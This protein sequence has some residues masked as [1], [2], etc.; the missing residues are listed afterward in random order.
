M[1]IRSIPIRKE[2]E[3]KI[4]RGQFKGREGKVTAVYRKKFVIHVERVTRDKANG[5][6]V[7]MGIDA[8]NVII[9]KLKVSIVSPF[10]AHS[11]SCDSS[12][13]FFGCPKADVTTTPRSDYSHRLPILAATTTADRQGPQEH[14]CTEGGWQDCDEGIL[15]HGAGRLSLLINTS[16][17][18]S[19][20]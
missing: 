14:Y 7:P 1:Q 10:C 16:S 20:V 19:N 2:D 3:V 5:A 13:R 18:I 15:C 6:P 9:T 17:L 12:C 4:V 8:S 11:Q